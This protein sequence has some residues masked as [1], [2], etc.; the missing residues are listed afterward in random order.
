MIKECTKTLLAE[1]HGVSSVFFAFHGLPKKINFPKVFVQNIPDTISFAWS[2]FL[3]IS[4]PVFV[5]YII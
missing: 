5:T 3:V 1:K 2:I 4:P